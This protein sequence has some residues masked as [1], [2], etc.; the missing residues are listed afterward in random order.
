MADSISHEPIKNKNLYFESW[1]LEKSKIYL[2]KPSTSDNKYRRGVL[3]CVTGD[4]KFPGAALISSAAAL[5][6]G[7]GMVRFMG[8]RKISQELIQFR[9]AIVLAKGPVD[10]LLIGSGLRINFFNRLKLKRLNRLEVPK[11]LDAGAIYL[12]KIH[13]GPTV[14]TPHAGELAK[15][16]DVASS[17]IEANPLHFAKDAAEKY[18]V[19]VLLKGY[20]TLVVNQEHAIQLP[21]APTWL[22][23][24]GTG[25][26]LAGILGA[27]IAIN[28]SQVTESNLIELSATA[29]LLHA[30]AAIGASDGPIDIETLIHE[31]P[32]VLATL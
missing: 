12:A 31:I 6:T 2:A 20:Q 13:N 14:I 7:V 18:G 10:V 19:T 17:E 16:L 4:R 8:P 22:A 23:T 5:A 11:V 1:N 25:D 26:V 29:S 24:A 27:L 21:P 28:K 3:G 15:L 30:K 32:K 9:P